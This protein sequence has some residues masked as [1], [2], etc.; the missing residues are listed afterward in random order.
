MAVSRCYPPPASEIRRPELEREVP[1]PAELTREQGRRVEENQGM[2]RSPEIAEA[3]LPWMLPPGAVHRCLLL[4][5]QTRR[6]TTLNEIALK[7]RSIR[8]INL[9][10][11][12]RGDICVS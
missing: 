6:Q 2:S 9:D 4:Q 12:L 5:I 3:G 1:N 8:T 7:R 10:S 11:S